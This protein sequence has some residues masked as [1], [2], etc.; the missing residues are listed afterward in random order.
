M[1]WKSLGA[2]ANSKLVRGEGSVAFD[3]CGVCVCGFNGKLTT[4]LVYWRN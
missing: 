4:V 3:F 1:I 2:V